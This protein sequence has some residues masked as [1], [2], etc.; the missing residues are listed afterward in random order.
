MNQTVKIIAS[1]VTK[2][3]STSANQVQL[4]I[5]ETKFTINGRSEIFT[6]ISFYGALGQVKIQS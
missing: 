3:P 6:R 4:G 1:A 2:S 5:S